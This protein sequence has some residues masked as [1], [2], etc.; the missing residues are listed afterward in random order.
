MP[1]G[2]VPFAHDRPPVR[3][4]ARGRRIPQWGLVRNS[5]GPLPESPVAGTEPVEEIEL[6]PYGSTNLRIT[7]FPEVS[8]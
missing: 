1:I 8:E 6:I 3:V 5:A 7:E 4:K 2:P